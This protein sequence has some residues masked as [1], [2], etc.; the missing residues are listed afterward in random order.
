V[1]TATRTLPR[2]LAG[3]TMPGGL[4]GSLGELLSRQLGAQWLRARE[5]L[6]GSYPGVGAGPREVDRSPPAMDHLSAHVLA[7]TDLG[8][9]KQHL[10][11]ILLQSASVGDD[12]AAGAAARA[13]E[14]AMLTKHA[15]VSAAGGLVIST[16]QVL[17]EL[18][19]MRDAFGEM[20][21]RAEA[22][23]GGAGGHC[24]RASGGGF[25]LAPPIAK[26]ESESVEAA[27]LGC[28]GLA[29]AAV[30]LDSARRAAE[31]EERCMR[32]NREK[33]GHGPGGHHG[34]TGP[35]FVDSGLFGSGAEDY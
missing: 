25:Q 7:S 27:V 2:T 11:E 15:Q 1:T 13:A 9:S 35:S 4:A 8:L 6:R 24:G 5:L 28:L 23:M 3:V 34:F 26:V 20:C 21:E 22:V 17:L 33:T 29:P 10:R 31:L 12:Q 16:R 30:A 18:R 14:E 32:H 19:S